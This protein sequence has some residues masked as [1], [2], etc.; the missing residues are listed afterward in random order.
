MR[1][2]A[3]AV[4]ALAVIG[5]SA[6][7]EAGGPLD[8]LLPDGETDADFGDFDAGD[9]D[10]LL[11]DDATL[12]DTAP[13]PAPAPVHAA[14]A[15]LRG[16]PAAT[17]APAAAAPAALK[18][19]KQQHLD[20]F[21]DSTMHAELSRLEKQVD[22]MQ[23]H[24]VPLEKFEALQQHTVPEEKY[25]KLEDRVRELEEEGKEMR[26]REHEL[27]HELHEQRASEA[28]IQKAVEDGVAKKVGPIVHKLVHTVLAVSRAQKDQTKTLT[29][30]RQE[31]LTVVSE[32]QSENK[33]FKDKATSDIARLKQ[34]L[35]GVLIETMPKWTTPRALAAQG[36]AASAP[37]APVAAASDNWND[38]VPESKAEKDSKE[39]DVEPAPAEK[40]EKPPKREPDGFEFN[41]LSSTTRVGRVTHKNAAY[42]AALDKVSAAVEAAARDAPAAAPSAPVSVEPFPWGARPP[43]SAAAAA[44]PAATAAPTASPSEMQAAFAASFCQTCGKACPYRICHQ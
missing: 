34:D 17:P 12:S 7:L 30:T 41:Q 3:W 2:R 8:D 13:P 15:H 21:T 10:E 5:Q 11:S 44:L 26:H 20:Q 9:D 6:A 39:L 43:Q 14:P 18:A 24:S 27:D 35:S 38:V 29:R 28:G 40:E 1:A 25:A 42:A 22:W 4:W 19:Q 37:A 16:R 31:M 23:R 36:Q 33:E 32:E